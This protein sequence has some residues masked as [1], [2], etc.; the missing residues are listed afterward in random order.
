V[1]PSVFECL[2]KQVA[3]STGHQCERINLSASTTVAQLFGSTVPRYCSNTLPTFVHTHH[4]W[5]PWRCIELGLNNCASSRFID[6]V[7]TF[8]FMEGAL[9]QAIRKGHWV[10][11][12]EINLAPPEVLQSLLPLLDRWGRE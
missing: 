5:F 4:T 6:G 8:E 7:R 2:S 3:D 12:D 10:L 9:T 1:Q 11:L